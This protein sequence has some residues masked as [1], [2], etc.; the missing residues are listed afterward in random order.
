MSRCIDTYNLKKEILDSTF[1]PDWCKVL[2]NSVIDRQPEAE[3]IFIHSH[4]VRDEDGNLICQRCG[5]IHGGGFSYCSY[6]G[7][8]M[9]E[10]VT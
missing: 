10:K 5:S 3:V 4:W 9:D 1:M 8:I 2:V 7:A 6:C